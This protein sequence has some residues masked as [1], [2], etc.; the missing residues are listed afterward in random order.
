MGE[1]VYARKPFDV[2]DF[3]GGCLFSQDYSESVKL[4][5]IFLSYVEPKDLVFNCR[6]VCK[7]WCN[8]IDEF[9][10]K[11]KC[12]KDNYDVK[13]KDLPWF[14]CYWILV[15]KNLWNRNLIKNGCG[16]CKSVLS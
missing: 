10:L 5:K 9:V 16:E 11:R 14:A 7:T 3:N 13:N 12:E 2:T 15:K 6:R 4:L 1:L 8:V